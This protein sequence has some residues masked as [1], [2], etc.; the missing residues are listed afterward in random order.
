[1]L[2]HRPQCARTAV[3]VG[4]LSVGKRVQHARVARE[5]ARSDQRIVGHGWTTGERHC[6]LSLGDDRRCEV[7]D[8]RLAARDI[9][10]MH[11]HKAPVGSGLGERSDSAKVAGLAKRHDR[12]TGGRGPFTAEVNGERTYR[13]PHAVLAVDQDQ[14]SV[15]DERDQLLVCNL[16]AAL[17][18]LDIAGHSNH[19]VAVVAG[20]VRFD[21]VLGDTG[22]LGHRAFGVLEHLGNEG[23][24]GRG[25]DHDGIRHGATLVTPPTGDRSHGWVPPVVY[26]CHRGCLRQPFGLLAS[27]RRSEH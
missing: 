1:V 16:H 15:V 26:P 24:Q 5:T 13:L 20:Q 6:G 27:R 12:K 17:Q 2:P 9:D 18:V 3:R 22:A 4:P 14:G 23:P 25:R 10:Q 21:Q 11:R 8:H 19:A 7:V